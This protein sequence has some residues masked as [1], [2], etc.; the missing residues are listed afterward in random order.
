MNE[1][2]KAYFEGYG[3]N[4]YGFGNGDGEGNG[5]YGFGNGEGYGTNGYGFGDGRGNGNG[6]GD[7]DHHGFGKGFGKGFIALSP[8]TAWHIIFGNKSHA[9]K[10]ITPKYNYNAGENIII[11]RFGL[12]ASLK[13]EDA[14]YYVSG[15]KTKV[16]C[17]GRVIFGS[18]KLVCEHRE[19]VEVL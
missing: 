7:G 1:Q 5:R 16:Q 11:C 2:K 17:S 18:D 15:T 12:H 10:A 3:Y 4:G 8:I 9:G 19:V 14:R 13:L 6:N